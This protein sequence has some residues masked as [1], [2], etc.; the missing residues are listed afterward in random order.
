MMR[1][2]GKTLDGSRNGRTPGCRAR[3]SVLLVALLWVAG[4]SGGCATTGPSRPSDFSSAGEETSP[5]LDFLVARDLEQDGQLEQALKLYARALSKDPESVYLLKQVAELSARQNRLTDALVYAERALELAPDDEGVRLFLGTL[6]RFRKDADNARRVLLT[7]EGEPASTDSALVLYGIVSDARSYDEARDLAE[8]LIVAEPDALRGHFALADAMEKLGDPAGSEAALRHALEL[9]PEEMA[10]YGALARGRR[11]RGDRV[12]EVEIYQEILIIHP[13]Q[14][15][16]LVAL[17]DA[18]LALRRID[19]A[20]A[21]LEQIEAAHPTDIRS[22]LRIAFIEL[23]RDNWPAASE[24]FQRA[25]AENPD[26]HEVRYF[27]GIALRRMDNED[28]SIAA[29]EAIPEDHERFPE[30][31]TQIAAIHER[32]GHFELAITQVELARTVNPSR[33][34]DLYLASLRS[35]SGDLDGALE[36]LEGLLNESPDDAELLYNIGVIHGEAKNAGP[37]LCPQLRGLHP[38]RARHR[39]GGGGGDDLAGP[40]ASAR[41]RLHHRQPRLGVLHAS[42]AA[43]G[44]RARRR[45]P[46]A[47][48]SRRQQSPACS[49]ADGR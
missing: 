33:P 21:T 27:L 25:L 34:L 30:A 36:F 4:L 45:G 35:K 19:D 20:V 43:D 10:L 9:H 17:S 12:G 14:H 28:E 8:W 46:G 41:R 26:Q 47:A 38:G 39:S 48:G 13:D 18:Q 3:L 40:R 42:A 44:E 22:S 11:D 15:G 32:S 6:Y 1:T 37:S 16:T 49:R 29:F 23:E 7:P 2:L 24:R 5:E 31:R